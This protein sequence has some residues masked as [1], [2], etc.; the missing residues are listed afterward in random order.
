MGLSLFFDTLTVSRTHT[1]FKS[2]SKVFVVSY[3]LWVS[4]LHVHHTNPGCPGAHY[5][6]QTGLRLK[7]ILLSLPLKRWD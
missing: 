1:I 2:K 6:D 4:S 3:G 5:V 7:E